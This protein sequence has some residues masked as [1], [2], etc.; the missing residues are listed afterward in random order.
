MPPD[1]NLDDALTAYAAHWEKAREKTAALISL[2]K[3]MALFSKIPSTPLE[4]VSRQDA[5]IVLFMR[6]E[7]HSREAV[8]NAIW[9]CAP[10]LRKDEKRDWRRYATRIAAYAFGLA[11]DMELAKMP[12]MEPKPIEATPLPVKSVYGEPEPQWE[13]P[14]LRMR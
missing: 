7:G 5:R 1:S 10:K 13:T 9:H 11:G 8:V 4:S 6:N 14:R 2:A 3:G 12:R